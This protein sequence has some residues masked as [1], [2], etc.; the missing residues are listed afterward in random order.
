MT[1]VADLVKKAKE[2]ED[3]SIAKVSGDFDYVPPPEGITFGRFI[4]YIELG[5]HAGEYNGKPKAPAPQVRTTIELL[6][7]AKNIK[8]ID[9]EGGGKKKIAD[10]LSTNM[11]KS[12]SDKAKF[13]KLFK[14]LQAGR[15]DITHIA[16][17]LGE[18]FLPTIF[19]S[20]DDKD[21]K[22]VYANIWNKEASSWQIAQ[23][24]Q[25]DVLAG[26]SVK[27]PVPEPLSALKIFLWDYPTKETWDSLFIDGERDIKDA[28]GNVTGKES[29]NWIQELILSAT[30]FKGSP[31]DIMLNGLDKLPTEEPKTEIKTG[32]L[33]DEP[34]ADVKA[35]TQNSAADALAALGLN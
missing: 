21:P 30:N 26:T 2:T 12:T 23:A 6:H 10:R 31:L 20:K 25:N 24:V 7:P 27:I 17:M 19:H 28:K 34:K 4:E 18:G 5:D 32:A 8:E 15:A 1:S 33:P 29:K 9:V 3:Q 22:K 13:F 11:P 14:T 16:E 35:E